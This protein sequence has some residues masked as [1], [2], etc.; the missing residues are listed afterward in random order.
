MTIEQQAREWLLK[1]DNYELAATIRPDQMEV[2]DPTIVLLSAFARHLSSQA[3]GNLSEEERKIDE[4]L[5]FTAHKL[6]P[7]E[8]VKWLNDLYTEQC[9]TL[10]ECAERHKI[11]HGGEK[12]A[13]VA[14]DA[15][16]ELIAARDHYLSGWVAVSEKE[17]ELGSRYLV[18]S[19]TYGEVRAMWWT[20]PYSGENVWTS[21]KAAG[22][23]FT[24]EI[25]THYAPLP[26]PPYTPQQ[27]KR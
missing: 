20:K 12:L 27:E 16:D 13:K 17:P 19:E 4:I 24:R 23:Y 9:V 26:I 6:T 8:A 11:G 5:H 1:D 14:A 25:G 18:T 3:P 15:I 22:E 7:S 2:V 21:R 10:Q